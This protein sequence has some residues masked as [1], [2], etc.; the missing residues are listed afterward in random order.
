MN[1]YETTQALEAKHIAVALD[2]G[3]H[4]SCEL[5]SNC[6]LAIKLRQLIGESGLTMEQ[7]FEGFVQAGQEH[8]GLP[9]IPQVNF[10]AYAVLIINE[11]QVR[12]D[13]TDALSGNLRASIK[14]RL[15]ELNDMRSTLVGIGHRLMYVYNSNLRRARETR[16]LPIPQYTQGELLRTGV[17]VCLNTARDGYLFFLPFTYRP[18]FIVN[19]GIRCELAATDKA[20]LNQLV[21]LGQ[22][23]KNNRWITVTLLTLD[24]EKFYHYHGGTQDCWGQIHHPDEWDGTLTQLVWHKELLER[25][26]VT[27]NYNSMMNQ[28]QPGHGM[29]T[30]RDLLTRST[31]L[32]REG[33]I[34]TAEPTPESQQAR[35]GW[36]LR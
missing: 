12:V 32:G 8:L 7:V 33:D 26:L 19:D 18:G 16:V 22:E 31:R 20:R 14:A 35:A 4:G 30:A 34:P 25:S 23:I 36:R 1:L 5:M 24:G 2:L 29:P 9:E 28:G 11:H 17:Q 13:L 6:P 3:V 15:R 27:I 21:I 10:Q